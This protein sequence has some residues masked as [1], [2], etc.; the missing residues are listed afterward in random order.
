MG[1]NDRV[2]SP[3]RM[4]SNGPTSLFVITKRGKC[5]DG[6]GKF[7]ICFWSLSAVF[8]VSIAWAYAY[9]ETSVAKAAIEAGLQQE[10]V[11]TRAI[12]VKK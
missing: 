11:G 5:M 3:G 1:Q 2:T 4:S 12:W 8:V 7:W 9:Y 10:Y 6:E